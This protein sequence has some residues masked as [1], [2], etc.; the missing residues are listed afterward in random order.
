MQDLLRQ[1]AQAKEGE[2][3]VARDAITAV[4]TEQQSQTE[5][6]QHA[7]SAETEQLRY[8]SALSIPAS[9]LLHQLG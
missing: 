9:Q 7:I 3:S 8:I 5:S 1:V 4:K 6:L 2:L